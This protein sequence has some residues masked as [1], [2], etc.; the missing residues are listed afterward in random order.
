MSALRY[1]GDVRVRVTYVEPRC[2]TAEERA[3]MG[4]YPHG[5]YRCV[6]SGKG[7]RVV[8]WTAPPA[9]LLHAVDSSEAF[10]D[11]AHAALAFV[12][13]EGEGRLV[14]AEYDKDGLV[15]RRKKV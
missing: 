14:Y 3:T 1:S 2:G 9:M 13:D 11:A 12:E 6:V 5:R 4:R 7:S 15:V 10:D 8:V